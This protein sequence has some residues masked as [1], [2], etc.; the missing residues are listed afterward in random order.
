ML[1]V[2]LGGVVG[3]NLVRELKKLWDRSR[4]ERGAPFCYVTEKERWES[5]DQEVA[6]PTNGQSTQV[7]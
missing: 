3:D 1:G 6:H 2:A 4:T 7:S 5:N